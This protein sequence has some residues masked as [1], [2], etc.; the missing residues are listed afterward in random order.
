MITFLVRDEWNNISCGIQGHTTEIIIRCAGVMNLLISIW[1]SPT[2]TVFSVS[3]SW[4][5]SSFDFIYIQILLF[6]ILD[7]K[8]MFCWPLIFLILIY[9]KVGI[10]SIACIKIA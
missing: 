2:C 4:S 3:A 1:W 7:A 9:S 5:T 10:F 8:I 6:A